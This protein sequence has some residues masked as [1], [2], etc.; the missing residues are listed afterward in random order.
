MPR[1][2][3]AFAGGMAS[4]LQV[5]NRREGM[6]KRGPGDALGGRHVDTT[7]KRTPQVYGFILTALYSG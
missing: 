2:L 1:S 3:E 4:V 5:G 6:P 7:S